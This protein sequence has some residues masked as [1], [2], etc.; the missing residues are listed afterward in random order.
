VQFVRSGTVTVLGRPAGSRD[1]RARV[2]YV[3]QAPSVY[4]DLTVPE[5]ARYFATLAGADAAAARRA[6]DVLAELRSARNAIN[7]AIAAL[8]KAEVE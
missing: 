5:N 1:L 4:S 8:E 2:G 7:G 3:T 6:V